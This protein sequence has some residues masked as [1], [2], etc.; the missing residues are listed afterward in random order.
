M[1]AI[2][3]DLDTTATPVPIHILGI[4][5]AG[6]E[7]GNDEIVINRVIPWLQDTEQEDVWHSW[8]VTWRDVIILDR[9]NEVFA[10]YNLTTNNLAIAANR[11]TLRAWL[12]RAALKD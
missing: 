3:A 7:S 11:D 12:L 2:Q 9:H 1:N 8:Q 6:E 10:I 5:A 4:N